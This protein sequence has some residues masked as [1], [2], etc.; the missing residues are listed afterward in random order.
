M[1][2]S[3]I[4]NV[5]SNMAAA[6]S[7]RPSRA[8]VV[9]AVV[10]GAIATIGILRLNRPPV[11]HVP[12]QA[13]PL[14]NAYD[15]FRSA[16]AHEVGSERLMTVRFNIRSGEIM[17]GS[18]GEWKDPS[19]M[20]NDNQAALAAVRE[21][22]R[23]PCVVP[24]SEMAWGDVSQ[25]VSALGVL[26]RLEA[27]NRGWEDDWE[28]SANSELDGFQFA[29]ALE[30]NGWNPSSGWGSYAGP[31]ILCR[32]MGLEASFLHLPTTER[33]QVLARL[34]QIERGRASFSD[35]LTERKWLELMS[36]T[37]RLSRRNWRSPSSWRNFG[38]VVDMTPYPHLS[39]M[40]F[41]M[42]LQGTSAQTVVNNLAECYDGWIAVTKQPYA[43]RLPEPAPPRDPMNGGRNDIIEDEWLLFLVDQTLHHFLLTQLAL[44]A[45]RDEHGA[46][47]DRLEQLVPGYLTALPPDP[48]ALH[49]PIGY[50]RTAGTYRLYSIG[51]DGKDDH[52][53]AV[54]E[55]WPFLSASPVNGPS[56]A[57]DIV[58]G[59][60]AYYGF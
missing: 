19:D 23:Y 49:A 1:K 42:R 6:R 32:R 41:W 9:L 54:L 10:W 30:R 33:H 39:E 11:I 2:R 24:R 51:P 28:G 5:V 15:Y 12:A 58:A 38:C 26:L 16:G 29:F 37:K 14:P 17:Q 56:P 46:Y 22:L 40:P 3:V 60:E 8:V 47:P 53:S 27:V 34:E 59:T 48:F 44:T 52:G 7:W 20:V 21:G 4:A 13:L 50:V 18:V 55:H 25:E 36:E 31:D 35:I 45:Y 57:G 43:A